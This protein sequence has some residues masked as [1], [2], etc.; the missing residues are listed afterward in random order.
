MNGYQP[1]HAAH[2][3]PA[4]LPAIFRGLA[5]RIQVVPSKDEEPQR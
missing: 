5:D 1:R 3:Q 2:A 4:E